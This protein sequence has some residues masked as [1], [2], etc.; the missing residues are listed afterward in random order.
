[1]A[2]KEESNPLEADRKA[3][4]K[5]EIPAQPNADEV[6]SRVDQVNHIQ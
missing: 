4:A 1:M 2:L 6:P 5:T 3:G